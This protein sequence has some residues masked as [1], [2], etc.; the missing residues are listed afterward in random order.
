MPKNSFIFNCPNCGQRAEFKYQPPRH[1]QLGAKRPNWRLFESTTKTLFDTQE[2]TSAPG[3]EKK[4]PLFR[5]EIKDI[6]TSLI[7][8]GV[9]GAIFCA[10]T[11]YV[12][13]GLGYSYA[14]IATGLMTITGFSIRY[15]RAMEFVRSLAHIIESEI[16]PN[17]T[18][19]QIPSIQKR[20]PLEVIHKTER[21]SIL[22]IQ[23]F[24]NLSPATIEKLSD[25][26][27]GIKSNGLAEADWIGSAGL[28]SS[29]EYSQ[30]MIALT[31]A[32]IIQWINPNAKN[33]GR[34]V[35]GPTGWRALENLANDK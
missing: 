1:S 7:D 8:A 17:E 13:Y 15:F 20:D 19:N 31:E 18:S 27:R 10:G 16:L 30:V 21:G 32:G 23:R 28:F 34:E 4:T 29:S 22:S 33:L 2:M 9:V 14:G 11:A 26:A 25:F 6:S 24:N 3:W 5:P 12:S 35:S